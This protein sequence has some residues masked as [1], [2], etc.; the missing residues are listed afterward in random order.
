M[1]FPPSAP[2]TRR[3]ASRPSTSRTKRSWS[4]VSACGAA[5]ATGL[6]GVGTADGTTIAGACA[7]PPCVLPAAGAGASAGIG[8][9]G[10]AWAGACVAG[11]DPDLP[12]FVSGLSCVPPGVGKPATGIVGGVETAAVVPSPV[13]ADGVMAGTVPATVSRTFG[14]ATVSVVVAVGTVGAGVAAGIA[15]ELTAPSGRGADGSGVTGAE[16]IVVWTVAGAIAEA[17]AVPG[18]VVAWTTPSAGGAVAA[19]TEAAAEATSSPVTAAA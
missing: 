3:R 4:L 2:E 19:T 5:P 18:T 12:S 1:P 13:A 9:A 7:A 10:A 14:S 15:V 17:E 11:S 6:V 8:A 16:T